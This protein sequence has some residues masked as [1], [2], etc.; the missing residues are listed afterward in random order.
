MSIVNPDL[1]ARTGG[2]TP[3]HRASIRPL[4]PAPAAIAVNLPLAAKLSEFADLLEQQE[5]DRFRVAAYRRAAAALSELDRPVDAILAD[6]G[7]EALVALPA[8]GRRIAAALAEMVA[9][10]RWS[11]LDR[12][13]GSLDP[14]S[15]FRTIPGIG[16]ELAGRLCERLQVESL[17]ALEA[18]AHDGRLGRV[19]GF[20][21]RR[22]KMVRA[23]LAERL[24]RPRLQRMRADSPKPP[25]PVLLDVDREYREKAEA[26][27]LRTI[28][29]RRFNPEGR[30]WLPI[31]HTRRGPWHFTALYSN[32]RFAHE[33]GRIG[34]WVVIYYQT[35]ESPEGQCTIVT[36]RRGP[37]AGSRVVR[38]RERECLPAP[39][40]RDALPAA[41][42]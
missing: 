21:P 28:A 3:D 4:T 6:G 24:G 42:S 32:T 5:A 25:V 20:G 26:G 29:P 23:T 39:P 33:V 15:L 14:E 18:A 13:R 19:E 16:P 27:R 8:I 10:G 41:V 35:D 40:A 1:L 2:G 22:V 34:D 12:L 37:L 9:T 11:Q 17:E 31:L 38:G 7:R 36:E 30:P